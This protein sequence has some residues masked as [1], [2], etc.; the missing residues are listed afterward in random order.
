VRSPGSAGC[1]GLALAG[2]LGCL[3]LAACRGAPASPHEELLF[4]ADR[5]KELLGAYGCAGCHVIPG[6]SGAHGMLGPPLERWAWRMYIA[7]RVPNRPEVL[8]QWIRDPRSIEPETAMP[9]L[10]VTDAEARSIA[11]YL[12]TLD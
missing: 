9:N 5:G 1:S 4:D 12:Y 3:T 8:V 7:G 6:V 10:G 11:A 2:L